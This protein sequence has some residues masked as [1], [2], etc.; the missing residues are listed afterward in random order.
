M[1]HAILFTLLASLLAV[2]CERARQ[3]QPVLEYFDKDTTFTVGNVR[4]DV[5]YNYLTIANASRSEALQAI[6]EANMG[7]FFNLE[8]FS[9]TP[10]RSL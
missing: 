10:A 4:Y 5:N 3:T 8:S 6:E 1:K 2:G 7:Y 9:G